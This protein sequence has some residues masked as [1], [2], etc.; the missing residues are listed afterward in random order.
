MAG[1]TKVNPQNVTVNPQN[2][3]EN[4]WE[5]VG[6][7]IGF[8][9]VD[10][11]NDVSGSVG[12]DGAVDSVYRAIQQFTTIIAAGPVF[13]SGTQQTFAAE[14]LLLADTSESPGDPDYAG[15]DQLTQLQTAIQGL[16]TV[17]GVD[18]SSATV[19]AT[20]LAIA[21]AAAV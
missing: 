10:Y 17:D 8:F 12:P 20:G 6:K 19:T 1:V 15:N 7:N 18:L 21:T 14:P 3:T 2:K 13:D 16:G 5:V 9:T 4:Q 11:I